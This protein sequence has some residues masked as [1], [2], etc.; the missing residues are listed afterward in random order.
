MYYKAGKVAEAFRS[1]DQSLKFNPNNAR[2]L[3]NYSY[4]LSIAK[5]NLGKALEMSTKAVDLEPNN[6]TYIDTK[7]WV[8]FQMGRYEQA[9]E[10]LRNAIAKSGSTSAVINEHYGDA[11]YMTGNKENAYI[12]WM[13]AKA[14]G[15]ESEK[16]D[17]KLRTRTYVP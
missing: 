10:V 17:E 13:K 12:Y 5:R 15:G 8:L 7:G 3:N 6:S 1:Y 11:L 16:L 2:I 14:I 4:Y 9:R